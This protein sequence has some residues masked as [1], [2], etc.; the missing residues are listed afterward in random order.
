MEKQAADVSAVV[1]IEKKDDDKKQ[2]KDMFSAEEHKAIKE[3]RAIFKETIDLDMEM[4]ADI[5]RLEMQY[6]SRYQVL[7]DERK[8]LLNKVRQQSRGD[9]ESKSSGDL[10]SFWMQVLRASYSKIIRPNDEQ[11]LVHLN[12]ISTRIFSNPPKFEISFHFD[13]NEY[14][15]NAVLNKTYYLK[16]EPDPGTPLIYD[17]AEI[18]KTEGCTIHWTKPL[19]PE[20]AAYSFFNYFSPPLLPASKSDPKYAEISAILQSDF[21]MGFYL[22][23]RVVPKAV[24]FFTG[25]I[26]DCQSTT[27]NSDS[28][29]ESSENKRASIEA[30][31]GNSTDDD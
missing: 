14:F 16:C 27:S 26:K 25:E 24:I 7:Y 11:I 8:K 1:A 9:D 3:L 31:A 2:G 19:S 29:S 5:Y 23:E 15:S 20:E 22:K 18:V 12:D 13:P 21:Q 6:Q 4:Q 30:L 28:D 17:G 10:Q